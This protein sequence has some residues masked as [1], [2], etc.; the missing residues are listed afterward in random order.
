MKLQ[1][2]SIYDSKAHAHLPPFYMHN[3]DM[4]VRAVTQAVA[5]PAHQFAKSPEDYTLFHLGQW[6][7]ETAEF[8]ADP[9]KSV[10]NCQELV[11]HDY[12]DDQFT[13]PLGSPDAMRKKHGT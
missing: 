12:N 10:C 9:K 2:F 4:A 11:K 1:V 6:D 5:D 7:D 8:Q 13:L 3:T